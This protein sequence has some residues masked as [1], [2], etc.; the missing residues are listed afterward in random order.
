MSDHSQVSYGPTGWV[1]VLADGRSV[2]VECW[3]PVNGAALLVNATDGRLV[4][5]ISVPGFVRLDRT[6]PTDR[7]L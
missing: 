4:Q 1:A 2:N 6:Q 7:S 3:H 5:A